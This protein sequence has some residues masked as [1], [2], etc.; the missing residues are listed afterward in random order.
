VNEG[1]V[2]RLDES[3]VRGMRSP[4]DPADPIGPKWVEEMMRDLTAFGGNAALLLL[5]A[6]SIGYLLFEKKK[7]TALMMAIAIGGGAALSLLLK[8][9]YDRPRPELVPYGSYV[10]TKSFPSGHSMLSTVTYLTLGAVLAQVQSRWVLKI[11]VV[12]LAILIAMLVGVS[13]VYLGVHWPS[14][15]LAGW[16]A[17][18]AWALAVWGVTHFL[19]RRGSIEPEPPQRDE[20]LE[21]QPALQGERQA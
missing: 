20:R 2:A 4:T 1:E 6:A 18:S 7:G 9:Y 12:G 21:L 19:Q 13:R 11:Y 8:D 5:S 3:L 17:G 16:A 15:V 10:L 14:D